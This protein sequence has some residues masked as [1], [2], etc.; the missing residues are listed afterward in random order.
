MGDVQALTSK[1]EGAV[2]KRIVRR[3][4]GYLFGKTIGK[5]VK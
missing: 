5:I 4:L 1:K 3:V 2:Q